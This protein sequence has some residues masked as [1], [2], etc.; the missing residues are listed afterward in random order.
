M[1]E[2]LYQKKSN[3]VYG[4]LNRFKIDFIILVLF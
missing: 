2:V 4:T 3:C 1:F